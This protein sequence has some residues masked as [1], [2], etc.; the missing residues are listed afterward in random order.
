MKKLTLEDYG[1]L[2]TYF[3]Q[4]PYRISAYSLPSMIAWS[5]AC[6][7]SYY[8]I[9]NGLL[10]TATESKIQPENRYLVLPINPKGLPTAEDLRHLALDKGYKKFCFVPED[11]IRQTDQEALGHSF[12]I[13]EQR[14]Y[15][16]YIYL[17]QD[18]ATLKG[19]RYAKKRNLIHQFSREYDHRDRVKTGPIIPDVVPECLDFLEKWCQQRA[20]D[21]D[22]EENRACEKDAV[23]QALMSVGELDWR[24]LWIRVDGEIC[25]FAIMSHLTPEMGVLNFEKAYPHIKGLYQFLDRE[26][27]LQLFQDY[28]Y[29]NKE[30]DMGLAALADS[31]RSYH[32]IEKIKSFC[33]K[34]KAR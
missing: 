19:N 22:Q 7:Q 1:L 2:K 30:S 18:L 21:A 8:A 12:E 17:T 23:T 6:Y 3:T 32:P 4:Q 27:A 26:C 9:E 10:I 29:I 5:N 24:G 15:E 11:Y 34:L 25:A 31:K 33:L 20:C 13:T 28:R 16:D 14:E